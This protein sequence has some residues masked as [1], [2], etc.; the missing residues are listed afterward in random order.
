MQ[1]PEGR[2]ILP[3]YTTAVRCHSLAADS[4]Y[5]IGVVGY[6]F[7]SPVHLPMPGHKTHCTGASGIQILGT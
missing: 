5:C 2:S 7:F 6:C 4:P 3:H 1:K